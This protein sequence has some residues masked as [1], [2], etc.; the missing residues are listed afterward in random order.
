[1]VSST[2]RSSVRR[3]VFGAA[4][5]DRLVVT[6]RVVHTEAK[7]LVLN[8]ERWARALGLEPVFDP[9]QN[10]EV[11]I[12]STREARGRA[13]ATRAVKG[14]YLLGKTC[15][16]IAADAL[17]EAGGAADLFAAARALYATAQLLTDATPVTKRDAHSAFRAAECLWRAALAVSNADGDAAVA[18]A[19]ALVDAAEAVDAAA[20]AVT[21]FANLAPK[22]VARQELKDAECVWDALCRVRSAQTPAAVAAL[23]AS[24]AVV[25]AEPA[26]KAAARAV[27]DT[28]PAPRPCPT[29][30]TARRCPTTRLHVAGRPSSHGPRRAAG[31]RGL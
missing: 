27:H 15:I 20:K 28:K 11:H 8:T 26:E 3:G 21:T 14:T 13:V 18:A 16:E 17:V 22:I 4:P 6:R 29:S 2:S 1:M 7:H 5:V 23:A 30:R 10:K 19:Q 31:A 9:E 24:K 12:C 25:E